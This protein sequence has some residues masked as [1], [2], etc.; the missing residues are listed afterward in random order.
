MASP[1]ASP[2]TTLEVRHM[3]TAP[4]E[5]VFAAWTERRHLEHWMCNPDGKNVTKYLEFDLREGG[6]YVLELLLPDGKRYLNKGTYKLVQPPEKLVFSWA[7]EKF[8]PSGNKTS[9]LNDTWVTVEFLA[10]GQWT[11]VVLK[12]DFL[13]DAA[14]VEAHQKGWIGCLEVLGGYLEAEK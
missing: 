12:H 1:T 7:W 6:G 14:M 3:F 2:E 8:D 13:P 10:R 5:K 4:R 11:E 9:E